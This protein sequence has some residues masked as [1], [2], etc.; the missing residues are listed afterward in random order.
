MSLRKE[1]ASE[2]QLHF[3]E[4][5]AS[6]DYRFQSFVVCVCSVTH[7]DRISFLKCDVSSAL[8]PSVHHVQDYTVMVHKC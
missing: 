2:L 7:N 5:T 4:R 8:A 6:E 3:L 1:L